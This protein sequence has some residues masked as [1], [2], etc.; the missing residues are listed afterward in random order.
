LEEAQTLG[1][2]LQTALH[3]A[4]AF[5]L[6]KIYVCGGTL[7]DGLMA[8]T[9]GSNRW[10]P[11]FVEQILNSAREIGARYQRDV[12]HAECVTKNALALYH[13]L[14]GE[15]RL[16]FRYEVIL[17][18]A[19]QLHDIGTFI[20]SSAHHKHSRYLIQNSE[21]FGLGEEDLMLVS[22]VARY[23]RRARPRASHS[24]YRMLPRE[25]RLAVSRLAAILRVADALDRS[26]TQA[27]CDIEI[28]RTA[29][30]V[31]IRTPRHGA[32]EAEQRALRSKGEMFAEVFGRPAALQIRRKS[33][34][35]V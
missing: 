3:M 16:G 5:K 7:R 6:K 17:M 33:G 25:K 30:A 12:A 29:E 14:A 31:R 19:A 11:D 27:I 22:L 24:D 28:R 35:G 8:E 2:A 15:H 26:H 1:P 21:I 9:A 10:D 34:Q 32:F 13:A 18:V 23:H 20:N 4:R